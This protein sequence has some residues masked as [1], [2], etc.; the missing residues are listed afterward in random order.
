MQVPTFITLEDVEVEVLT[1]VIGAWCQTNQMDPESQCVRAVT[2]TAFDLMEA[3]FRTR[4]SL[5]IA[6]VNALHPDA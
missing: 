3:G 5:S 6:L 2:A 4:E 1:S